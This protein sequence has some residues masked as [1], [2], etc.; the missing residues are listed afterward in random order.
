VLISLMSGND[1][2][3]GVRTES[4]LARNHHCYLQMPPSSEPVLLQ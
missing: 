1:L 2:A 3:V 4:H